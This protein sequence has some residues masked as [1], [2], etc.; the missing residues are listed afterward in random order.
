MLGRLLAMEAARLSA[1][2]LSP[3]PGESEVTAVLDFVERVNSAQVMSHGQFIEAQL[4]TTLVGG[5]P[6][7]D[8]LRLKI[9]D[10]RQKYVPAASQ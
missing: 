8:V 5:T 3:G 4:A 7:G 9:V 6:R 1:S 10:D 2:P